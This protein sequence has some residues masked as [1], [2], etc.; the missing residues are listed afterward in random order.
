MFVAALARPEQPW[1][2]SSSFDMAFSSRGSLASLYVD[3]FITVDPPPLKHG[4]MTQEPWGIE[5]SWAAT[6]PRAFNNEFLEGTSALLERCICALQKDCTGLGVGL[7]GS[8][9]CG[10]SAMAV[11]LSLWFR[12]LSQKTNG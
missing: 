9:G 2:L 7:I 4:A 5:R 3:P 6:D 8:R 11:Q 10:K 1:D 12:R